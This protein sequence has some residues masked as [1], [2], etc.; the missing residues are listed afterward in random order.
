MP[1]AEALFEPILALY[2]EF[3]AEAD[4]RGAYLVEHRS[5][6]KLLLDS[7]WEQTLINILIG[8]YFSHS[9]PPGRFHC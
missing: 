2:R 6:M 4:K 8:K 7:I 1:V 3:P 5:E 9:V